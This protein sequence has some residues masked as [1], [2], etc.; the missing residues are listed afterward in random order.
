MTSPVE[1]DPPKQTDTLTDGVTLPRELRL[2]VEELAKAAEVS[3]AEMIVRLVVQ[4]ERCQ[5]QGHDLK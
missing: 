2:R 4:G 3:V 1:F 5:K